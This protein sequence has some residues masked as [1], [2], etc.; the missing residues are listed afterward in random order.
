[1]FDINWLF[2]FKFVVNFRFEAIKIYSGVKRLQILPV[3][4]LC[5]ELEYSYM[6]SIDILYVQPQLNKILWLELILVLWSEEQVNLF[7]NLLIQ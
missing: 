3:V 5:I 1:M 7:A 4:S 6:Y 2:V